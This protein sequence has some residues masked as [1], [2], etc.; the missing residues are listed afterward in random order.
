M[1]IIE[2]ITIIIPNDEPTYLTL[3]SPMDSSNNS[4]LSRISKTQRD[5]PNMANIANIITNLNL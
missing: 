2:D 4:P 1:P 3:D 5:I